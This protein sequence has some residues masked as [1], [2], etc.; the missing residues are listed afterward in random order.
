MFVL[1]LAAMLN[2]ACAP[3]LQSGNGLVVGGVDPCSGLGFAPPGER[4]EAATVTVREGHISWE[5]AGPG[6][7]TMILPKVVSARQT[8]STNEL[9]RFTLAPGDYVLEAQFPPPSNVTPFTAVTVKA[10]VTAVV[11]I[12]NMCK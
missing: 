2:S 6:S 11:D 10:G 1:V 7:S 9:Y 5:P 4:Y 3:A 12:P 8:V